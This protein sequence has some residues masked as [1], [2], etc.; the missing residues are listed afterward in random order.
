MAYFLGHRT[1]LL[2]WRTVGLRERPALTKATCPDECNWERSVQ[3]VVRSCFYHDELGPFDLLCGDA[4]GRRKREGVVPHVWKDGKRVWSFRRIKPDVYVS[5]PEAVFLQIAQRATL[6]ELVELGYELC[7]CYRHLPE[8]LLLA[9]AS[10][11]SSHARVRRLTTA[12]KLRRYIQSMRGHYGCKRAARALSFVADNSW[13]VME[14]KLVMLL[15]MPTSNGGLGLPLPK[16]NYR[17]RMPLSAIERGSLSS[18]CVDVCWP[19]YGLVLEYDS[20]QHHA[21]SDQLNKDSKKRTYLELAGYRV[22]SVTR[23]QLYDIV[24]FDAVGKWVFEGLE[25]RCRITTKDFRA[26]QHKLRARLLWG[27]GSTD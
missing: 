20:D 2:W 6:E 26:R 12:K 19:E 25:K 7:G 10:P 21:N 11:D 27:S 8:D 9:Y 3:G 15:C 16:L 17:V 22:L 18:Y 14:T 4:S 5:S 13:S 23:S 24:A 1:A